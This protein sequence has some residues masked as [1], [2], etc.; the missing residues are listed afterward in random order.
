MIPLSFP[1][2]GLWFVNR[3]DGPS[4]AY[5]IPVVARLRGDLNADALCDAVRDVV[6]RHEVL[7]TVYR[8][9]HGE[10]EQVVLPSADV[11]IGRRVVA[12][13]DVATEM[14]AVIRH[15]IDVTAGIPLRGWLFSTSDR[16]HVLVLVVHHI[17]ADG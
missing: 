15:V 2:R 11:E 5:N 3:L 13:A 1:Q 14:A 4:A 12:V 8:E 16:D 6:A 7:R 17:A 9:T 10:P